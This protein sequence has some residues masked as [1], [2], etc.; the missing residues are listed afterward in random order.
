MFLCIPHCNE[1]PLPVFESL[2]EL[3]SPGF[4]EDEASVLFT[5]SSDTIVSDVGFTFFL[6]PQLFSQKELNDLTRVLKPFK[7]F[8]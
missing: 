5:D 4:E 8:F 6:T 1:I 7:K 2:P 3:A